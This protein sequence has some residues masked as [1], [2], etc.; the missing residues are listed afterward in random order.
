[1]DLKSLTI[2]VENQPVRLQIWDTQGQEQFFSLTRSYF[3]NC[4]GA[5]IVFDLTN[6]K[7]LDSVGKYFAIFKDD[8]PADAHENIVLVGTKVDDVENR[9]ITREQA[10]E[11]CRQYGCIAYFETSATTGENV[12]DA[13]FSVAARAFQK[14]MSSQVATSAELLN[15][16]NSSKNALSDVR[17]SQGG[18]HAQVRSRSIN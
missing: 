18:P 2:Q 7:S 4:Q 14:T 6:R 5:V 12:D 3:R 10:E 15:G 16:L 11:V 9:Q 1:M 17:Q 13:F 8:S